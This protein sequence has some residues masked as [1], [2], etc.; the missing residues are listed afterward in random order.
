MT[1]CLAW[2]E[3]DRRIVALSDRRSSVAGTNV[4]VVAKV[5]TFPQTNMLMMWEGNTA[6][7]KQ[8][9]DAIR[10]LFLTQPGLD[11]RTAPA[12]EIIES[13]LL[14]INEF[15]DGIHIEPI[16]GIDTKPKAD[17]LSFILGAYDY[18]ADRPLLTRVGRESDNQPWVANDCSTHLG[19]VHQPFFAIGDK[20]TV[21][22][23]YSEGKGV[24]LAS[25]L[26][27]ALRDAIRQ[28]VTVGGIPQVVTL[29]RRGSVEFG[30]ERDG[31]RYVG[32]YSI[33]KEAKVDRMIRFVEYENLIPKL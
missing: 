19:S 3:R 29:D 20:S 2:V 8:V 21:I 32:G 11:C 9:V 14:R 6:A 12:S 16:R 13:T 10:N 33:S 18:E 5:H 23:D 4:D 31:V 15:W 24:L 1:L 22:D 26:G 17:E 27:D 25:T 30:V 7:A 28:G